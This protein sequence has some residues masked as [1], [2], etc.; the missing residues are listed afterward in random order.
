L[1]GARQ[2]S[3][4]FSPTSAISVPVRKAEQVF[5]LDFIGAE[6]PEARTS[7]SIAAMAAVRTPTRE[8]R[9]VTCRIDARLKEPTAYLRAE[10]R[11]RTNA[12]CPSDSRN[13]AA[14]STPDALAVW[15]AIASISSGDRQS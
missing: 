6:E 3:I 12:H 4:S 7:V 9:C 10:L 14:L 1:H 15:V 2:P 13:Q 11:R 8:D 5:G